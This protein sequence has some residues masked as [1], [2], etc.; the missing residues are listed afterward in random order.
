MT[1]PYYASAEQIMRDRSEL[2]R[3]E[4]PAGAASSFSPTA[5]EC[6]LS[7]RTRRVLCTRSANCTTVSDSRQWASTT[8]SRI[9]AARA[10]STQTC[11]GYSYDR[12]DVTGRSLANAY[13]QT[14]ERSSPSSPSR[15]RSRSV[16]PRSV[17]SE[18]VR[19]LSSTGSRTT[20]PSRTSRNSWSWAHD[21]TDRDGDA[22]VVPARPRPRIRSADCSRG[23]PKGRPAPAGTTESEPRTLDVSAL[24]VAVLDSN[25]PRRAF[26][27]IA[28]TVLE[29]MLPAP[30]AVE[31]APPANGDAPS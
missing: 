30:A 9:C 6:S 10:S 5:T 12:R 13:A 19:R 14:L 29:E 27:R 4:L 15:T 7:P 25:R 24:E 21:R 3:K 1:M 28:G 31:D 22:R 23:A 2:A 17:A 11:V 18:A 26:K 20:D 8:S 16:L